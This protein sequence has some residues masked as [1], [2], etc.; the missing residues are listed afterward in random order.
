MEAEVDTLCLLVQPELAEN[1]RAR[2]FD[3]KDIKNKH[4][5]RPVGQADTGSRGGGGRG[6]AL[7]WQTETGN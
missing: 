3:T 6:L 4:S 5:S 2:K 1:Q 7:P